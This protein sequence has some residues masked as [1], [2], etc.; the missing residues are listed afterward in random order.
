MTK[1]TEDQRRDLKDYVAG[2]ND[3]TENVEQAVNDALSSIDNSDDLE[4]ILSQV[5]EV[6]FCADLFAENVEEKRK[7][8]EEQKEKWPTGGGAV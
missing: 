4:H 1:I 6:D 5:K 2:I 3:R 8:L 7:W